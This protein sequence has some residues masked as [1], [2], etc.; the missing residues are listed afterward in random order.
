[1]V[2]E[3]IPIEG[4][5]KKRVVRPHSSLPTCR[6]GLT[7]I[8]SSVLFLRLRCQRVSLWSGTSVSYPLLFDY[9]FTHAALA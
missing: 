2:P 5:A 6:W 1:M 9:I 4:E 8:L 7:L 3:I